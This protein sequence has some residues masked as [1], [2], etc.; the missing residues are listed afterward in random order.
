MMKGHGAGDED[1]GADRGAMAGTLLGRHGKE[2]GEKQFATRRMA[3]MAIDL[4]AM[5]ATISRTTMFIEKRGETACRNELDMTRAFC[6][7]AH[8]R[9]SPGESDPNTICSRSGRS[10]PSGQPAFLAAFACLA[11]IQ[12]VIIASKCL[13]S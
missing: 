9:S 8:R 12:P 13:G 10:S 3:D 2:I 7:D 11:A 6:R 4:I 1:C 5:S